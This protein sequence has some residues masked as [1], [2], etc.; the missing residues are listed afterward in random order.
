MGA[1]FSAPRTLDPINS[2][3]V[4]E[5]G[6]LGQAQGSNIAWRTSFQD[7][8]DAG[9]SFALLTQPILDVTHTYSA[10]NSWG[11]Y[12]NGTSPVFENTIALTLPQNAFTLIRYEFA[13]TGTS[14]IYYRTGQC[15]FRRTDQEPG[16]CT[17]VVAMA[18][19]PFASTQNLVANV[20][21]GDDWPAIST[22][23]SSGNDMTGR[24]R[25]W[26]ESA[27]AIPGL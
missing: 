21:D 26:Y 23:G 3:T 6:N 27:G 4:L 1:D 5:V 14:L 7:P 2:P 9:S 8:T 24:I 15:V 11:G 12:S 19:L 18:G 16:V 20:D 17:R 10:A 22:Q 25:I 13:F